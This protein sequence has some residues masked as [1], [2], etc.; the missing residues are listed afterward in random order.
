MP[1]KQVGISMIGIYYICP[2]C[3]QQIG[4]DYF[5]NYCPDC[6]GKLC[7]D[8]VKE[9]KEI[10]S[11]YCPYEDTDDF[12]KYYKE[13]CRDSKN[14]DYVKNNNLLSKYAGRLTSWEKKILLIEK[15]YL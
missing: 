15:G 14:C 12:C 11:Q 10:D 6:G 9:F 1:D 5:C 4:T 8:N 3:S 2:H 13:Q 7:W